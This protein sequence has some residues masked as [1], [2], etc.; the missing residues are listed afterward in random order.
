MQKGL[1]LLITKYSVGESAVMSADAKSV[2]ISGVE[3]P[4]LPWEAERRIS[5]IGNIY[6]SGRLGG[7]CTYRIS[8]TAKRGSDIFALLWREIG[9]LTYTL[10][11]KA[12]D[13]F[14]I[15][16][17]SAMNCIVACECGCVAT[18]ELAATLSEGEEDVDKHEIICEVGVA[19]DRVVDTQVPQKSIY[20]FGKEKATFKDVDAELYGYTEG[21]AAVIRTAFKLAR[22]KAYREECLANAAHIDAVVEAAKLSLKTLENVKVGG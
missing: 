20:V 5:E 16:G 1:D 14:A 13:I 9:I 21:E 12:L 8:H 15:G 11:T 17:E 22:D 10:G 7:P 4:L 6:K 18:V 3:Y 2:A 19:C